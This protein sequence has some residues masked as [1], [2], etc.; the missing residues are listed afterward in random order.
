LLSPE[1]VAVIESLPT[2]RVVVVHVATPEV[3]VVVPQPVFELHATV[4]LTSCGLTRPLSCPYW[5]LTV[6]VNVT[7]CPETAGFWLE[8]SVV[9]ELAALMLK[10]PLCVLLD[11]L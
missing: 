2:G 4:P 6:A 9:L 7:D 5:P 10:F 8:V 11:P 3:T 1:Y